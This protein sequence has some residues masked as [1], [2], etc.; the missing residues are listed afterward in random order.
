MAV[1]YF[2][3]LQKDSEGKKINKEISMSAWIGKS[4]KPSKRQLTLLFVSHLDDILYCL[5]EKKNSL[6]VLILYDIR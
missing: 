3:S 4:I 1:I 2:S 5:K 6:E